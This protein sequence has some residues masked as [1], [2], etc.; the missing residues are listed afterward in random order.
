ME[1]T[2]KVRLLA[3]RNSLIDYERCVNG[4]SFRDL[5]VIFHLSE[6]T[7]HDIVAAA[8]DLKKKLK[9]SM[10]KPNAGWQDQA[11]AKCLKPKKK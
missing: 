5:A 9:R 6:S 11:F 7:V 4:A 10:K 3:Y 1:T 2:K 8:Q